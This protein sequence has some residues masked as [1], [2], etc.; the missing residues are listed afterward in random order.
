MQLKQFSFNI[1]KKGVRRE[2]GI[3]IDI[4]TVLGAIW[5]YCAMETAIPKICLK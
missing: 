1:A 4:E 5:T 2:N 3:P